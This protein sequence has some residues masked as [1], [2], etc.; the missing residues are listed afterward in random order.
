VTGP[1]ALPAD[2]SWLDLMARWGDP[3]VAAVAPAADG[4][5]FLFARAP[6]PVMEFAGD[7]TFVRS[8]GRETFVNPHGIRVG[9]DGNLWC[10]DAGGDAVRRFT[11]DGEPLDP[12]GPTGVRGRDGEPYG[13]PTDVCVLADGT[14]FVTDG[15]GNSHVHRFAPDGAHELT[16]GGRGSAPGQLLI[17]HGITA[18]AD[19]QHLLLAD[20]E[21]D[22]IVVTDLVGAVEDIWAGFARPTGVAV[23][24]DGRIWVSELGDL[25][26]R[27]PC[28]GPPAD[29]PRHSTCALV[30]DGR[31]T[32][33][34]GGPDPAAP[35]SF[36]AAH[37]VV[38]GP[39]GELYVGEVG[40]S[41]QPDRPRRA[42]HAIQRLVPTV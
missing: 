25:V 37:A 10:V 39:S 3:D 34:F 41:A 19:G 26:G 20:R 9:G 6:E 15:Y 22:R 12:L 30:V 42:G 28:T 7:G 33:R 23:A 16:W 1:G 38:A 5:V 13:L 35:G 29:P 8:W 17:P 24:P 11:L 14:A 36:E 4:R 21:N 2:P 40:R 31:I 27:M 18:T 32:A